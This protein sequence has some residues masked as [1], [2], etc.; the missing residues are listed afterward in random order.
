[1]NARGCPEDRVLKNVIARGA[2]DQ[3]VTTHLASCGECRDRLLVLETLAALSRDPASRPTLSG[4]GRLWWKAQ[5]LD[6]WD[7]ERLAA[8]PVDVAERVEVTAAGALGLALVYWQWPS[9]VRMLHGFDQASL[10]S[11]AITV[12]SPGGA[13]LALG[14]C[15]VALMAALAIRTLFARD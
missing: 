14:G 10:S 13:I 5:L 11:W 1:V 6:R 15:T 3:A 12:S 2:S 8:R 9:I 4:A 7:A